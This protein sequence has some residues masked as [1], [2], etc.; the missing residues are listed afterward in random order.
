MEATIPGLLGREMQV[1][2]GSGTPVSDDYGPKDSKFA[3]VS[4]GYRSTS[5]KRL[6]T[7][8]A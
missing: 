5:T 7:W 6:K 3:A 4:A 8:I 2:R 1:F